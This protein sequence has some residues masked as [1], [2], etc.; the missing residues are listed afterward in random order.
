MDIFYS[1]ARCQA[2]TFAERKFVSE[3]NEGGIVNVIPFDK[4]KTKGLEEKDKP[5]EYLLAHFGTKVPHVSSQFDLVMSKPAEA[6]TA[7]ENDVKGKMV[8][9]RRGGCPF[10]KKAAFHTYSL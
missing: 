3:L 10:V 6:C 9:V 1:G 8:L 5:I 7:L 4:S 2:A